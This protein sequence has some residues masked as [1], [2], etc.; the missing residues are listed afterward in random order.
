V[1]LKAGRLRQDAARMRCSL[2]SASTVA[3]RKGQGRTKGGHV[4][5]AQLLFDDVK[6]LYAS[7]VGV[8]LSFFFFGHPVLAWC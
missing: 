5:F 4:D 2:P 3:R 7:P 8:V 6:Y 1:L